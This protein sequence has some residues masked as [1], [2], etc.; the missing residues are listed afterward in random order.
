VDLVTIILDFLHDDSNCSNDTD[1][2]T[3]LELL[4]LEQ[5]AKERIMYRYKIFFDRYDTDN[6]HNSDTKIE[7]IQR[8]SI[9]R[10]STIDKLN[11]N[12]VMQLALII[13]NRGDP[14]DDSINDTRVHYILSKSVNVKVL[15]IHQFGV[16]KHFDEIDD[17]KCLQ[18]MYIGGW[19][20]E[21]FDFLANQINLN[22]LAISARC[23]NLNTNIFAKMTNLKILRLGDQFNSNVDDLSNMTNLEHLEFGK[24]FDRLIDSLKS[25]VNV[26]TLIFGNHFNKSIDCVKYMKKINLIRLGREFDQPIECLKNLANFE[27]LTF[28]GKIDQSIDPIIN[29]VNLKVLVLGTKR[30]NRPIDCLHKL[31]NIEILRLSDKFNQ[32]IECLKYMPNLQNLYLGTSFDKS[33]QILQF[34]KKLQILGINKK[35]MTRQKNAPIEKYVGNKRKYSHNNNIK[36]I[37]LDKRCWYQN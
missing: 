21:N 32:S 13:P 22:T 2:M 18:K 7:M 25:L 15:T 8:V 11:F 34:A 3:F 30:L 5:S 29:L 17:L 24:E 36:I 31:T 16:C 23:K 37:Y 26:R 35:L 12:I 28:F 33:V 10:M 9:I 6:L 20:Y 19:C 27:S 4:N 14:D 1:C